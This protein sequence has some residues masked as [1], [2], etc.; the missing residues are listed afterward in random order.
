MEGGRE[1][2][3]EGLRDSA[4]KR[5]GWAAPGHRRPAD[6]TAAAEREGGGVGRS[7]AGPPAF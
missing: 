6:R 3:G 2:G 1:E 7:K 4:S 5:A